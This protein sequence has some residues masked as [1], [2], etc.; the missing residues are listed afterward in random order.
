MIITVTL[1]PALDKTA[2]L[3]RLRPNA[4]N[5]LENVIV[6]AG[7]KGL[8]VSSVIQALGGR[9]IAIGFAGGA[10][11]D[12]LLDRIG[13]RGLEHDF[14]RIS[15]PTRTNLKLIARDGSLT[16]LNEPGPEVSGAELRLLEEK[17]LFYAAEDSIF[18][19]SGSLPGGLGSDTYLKFCRLLHDRNAKIFLDT[20]GEAFRLAMEESPHY[21][22]PNRYELF[23]YFGIDDGESLGEATLLSLCHRLLAAGPELVCLSLGREGALFVHAEGVFRAPALNVK[24][25]ST[26]G[27]G[28]AMTGALAWGIEHNFPR[29]RCYA[30]AMAAAAGAVSTEGTKAPDRKLIEK[31]LEQVILEKPDSQAAS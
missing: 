26:V 29:E 21:I 28:D 19:L 31:L 2:C 1:N 25:G 24:T 20:D 30:L 13:S 17:L 18:V 6:D 3:E 27:A 8:N 10:P 15:N 7:G 23:Q 22:K 12:E 14:V 4:L 5:R 9:S 11:G 16:E